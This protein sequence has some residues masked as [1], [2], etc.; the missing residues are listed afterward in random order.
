ME[1]WKYIDGYEGYYEVSTLGNVRSI[2][3]KVPNARHGEINC[4]GKKLKPAIDACGYFRVA[5]SKNR[6]LSTYKVHRLVMLAFIGESKLQVNHKNGI[7]TDNRLENLE[8]CTQSENILHAYQNNLMKP[9]IGSKNGNSKLNE[10]QVRIIRYELPRTNKAREQA[11][12]A[13]NVSASQ[14]KDIQLKR[15]NIW[16]NV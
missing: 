7:K 16:P 3:R 10:D 2:D 4:K 12:K 1:T 14:I 15:R 8:Y 9:S 11:A 13:F 6:K 5:L